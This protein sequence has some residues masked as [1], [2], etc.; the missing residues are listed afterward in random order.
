MSTPSSQPGML[1]EHAAAVRDKELAEQLRRAVDITQ[2]V[3]KL[4]SPDAA[5]LRAAALPVILSEIIREPHT[6]LPA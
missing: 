1:A 4:S 3:I 2:A 6:W 5:A